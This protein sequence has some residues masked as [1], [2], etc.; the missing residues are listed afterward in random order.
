MGW[1]VIGAI[2]RGNAAQQGRTSGLAGCHT[3]VS[4][5]ARRHGGGR[6]RRQAGL[7]FDGPIEE[8]DQTEFRGDATRGELV[9]DEGLPTGFA[10]PA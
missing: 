9:L 4:L 1:P 8:G 6:A 3:R 5:H 10:R 2:E 7:R